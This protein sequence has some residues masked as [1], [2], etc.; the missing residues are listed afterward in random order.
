MARG[1]HRKPQTFDSAY[2]LAVP[3]TSPSP[4]V[5]IQLLGSN[6]ATVVHA[7]LIRPR[8]DWSGEK[9]RFEAA[10]SAKREQGDVY[11]PETG[12]KLALARALQRLSRDLFSDVA[13]RVRESVAEQERLTA[14]AEKRRE[15]A[16]TPVKRRTR[17]EWEAM[18]SA[19][20]VPLEFEEQLREFRTTQ[21]RFTQEAIPVLRAKRNEITT[22]LEILGDSDS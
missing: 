12:E 4:P 1:K 9:Y 3:A 5:H 13:K 17:E 7:Q 8:D 10:E 19:R 20:M 22:A 14:E 21:S 18:Q 6:T 15:A 11:D 2:E 16:K